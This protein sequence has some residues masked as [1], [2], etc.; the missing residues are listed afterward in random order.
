VGICHP[1]VEAAALLRDCAVFLSFGQP[2][3]CPL[4]PL[5][6]MACGCV[7]IGYHGYG[8][9]EYF[10]LELSYPVPVGDTIPFAR[11][12]EGVLQAYRNNPAP[13]Q[14]QGAQAAAFVREHYSPAREEQDIVSFWRGILADKT[15]PSN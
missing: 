6:A 4:P 9:R 8:G 1:K 5:E 14:R 2:E 12:V 15:A 11:T 7:V 10:R 3:G 13:L